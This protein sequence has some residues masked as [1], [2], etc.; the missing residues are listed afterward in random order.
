MEVKVAALSNIFP[1]VKM[2]TIVKVLEQN[3]WQQEPAIETLLQMVAD[4]EKKDDHA[5]TENTRNVENDQQQQASNTVIQSVSMPQPSAPCPVITDLN[6]NNP[7]PTPTPTATQQQQ[8]NNNVN[9]NNNNNNASFEPLQYL[10]E[11]R[12]YIVRSEA[13]AVSVSVLSD[14]KKDI[15]DGLNELMSMVKEGGLGLEEKRAKLENRLRELQEVNRKYEEER[16]SRTN[17]NRQTAVENNHSTNPPV[18]SQTTVVNT[19]DNNNNPTTNNTN[20]TNTNPNPVPTTTTPLPSFPMYQAGYHQSPYGYAP[21]HPPTT[22]ANP[23]TYPNQMYY[24]RYPPVQ[25]PQQVQPQQ[26]QQQQQQPRPNI[27]G[28]P[29]VYYPYPYYYPQPKK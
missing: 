26:Q 11:L 20:N 10:Q 28:Y 6:Q 8:P 23:N 9:N 7:P 18:A 4:E 21:Y 1:N 13:W 19:V 25:V 24:P 29:E 27:G 3:N 12:N 16:A 14:L 5:K 17:A 2:G 15:T 22:A